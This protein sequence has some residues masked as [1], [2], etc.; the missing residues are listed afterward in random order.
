MTKKSTKTPENDEQQRQSRKELL[1]AR[2]QQRQLRNIRIGAIVIAV[3]I[4]VVIGIG[5]INELLI[6]PSRT[7]ATV[8]GTDIT[9][10]N[11]QDR[12][13]FERA[14][15]I[16]FLE[17]QLDAF[18]GD[19]G[20][21]QQFGG[22]VIN[23]LFDPEGMGQA[24]INAMAEE[25][26]TCQAVVDRGIVITDA[27][28]QAFIE[29]SY[30]YFPEDRQP[31]PSPEPTETIAPTPSITPLP[32]A[33]ITEVVP[34]AT[35]FPTP[36]A[37]P[38]ATPLPTATPVPEDYFLEQYGQRIAR[39][40]A[41]GVSEST[42]RNVIRAQLCRDRLAEAL[43]EEQSLGLTAPHASMFII[44]SETR[45]EADEALAQMD[46]EDFLTVWNQINS[47]PLDPETEEQPTTG[48]FEILWRTQQNL[49]ST[50]GSEIGTAAFELE[51]GQP[52]EVIAVDNGDGTTSYY[53]LLVSGREERELGEA[54]FQ[55]RRNEIA[56]AYVDELLVG[57]LQI[58]DLWRGRVP[59]V[60]ILDAKFLA[61]PTAT[62]AGQ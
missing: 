14:Q 47:R 31:T 20:I 23:E 43:A 56:Q 41:L 30:N 16:V 62:P 3:L 10:Q 21:V 58:N 40:S 37:G 1:I 4:V 35:L 7:V 53:I 52:S 28:V 9:L 36:T 50:A 44:S 59:T 27:D 29:A 8:A 61:Q 17:D 55:T 2:K 15:R 60:P 11:W 24:M 34:T 51:I 12:V 48:A 26:V 46:T 49:L 54:E 57:N 25:H 13:E 33:V 18:G 45:E 6:T 39:F 19:V 32:P 38:T 5:L 42:Y 22:Q